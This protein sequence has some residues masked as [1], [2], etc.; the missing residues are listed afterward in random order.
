MVAL[1]IRGGYFMWPILLLA[2]WGFMIAFER[3]YTLTKSSIIT[4][5]FTSSRT[6]KLYIY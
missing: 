3:F 5:K 2:I 4:K 1:F 6:I